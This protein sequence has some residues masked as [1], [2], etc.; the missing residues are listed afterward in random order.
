MILGNDNQRS[1]DERIRVQHAI[2]S[3]CTVPELKGP[4]DSPIL[5]LRVNHH[6]S[7]ISSVDSLCTIV[8]LCVV[9]YVGSM[10]LDHL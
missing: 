3:R 9:C 2:R 8:F 10:G 6:Q 7:A 5:L 1:P 4:I